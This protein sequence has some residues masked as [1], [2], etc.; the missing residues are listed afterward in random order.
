MFRLR[1][2]RQTAI[3]ANI[4]G[5]QPENKVILCVPIRVDWR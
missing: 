3:F 4:L 1:K 5:N 2:A